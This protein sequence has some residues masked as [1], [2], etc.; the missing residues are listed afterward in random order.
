MSSPCKQIFERGCI[1]DYA[2]FFKFSMQAPICKRGIC[3][4]SGFCVLPSSSTYL[5]E[6]YLWLFSNLCSSSS[7]HLIWQFYDKVSLFKAKGVHDV[8]SHFNIVIILLLK[9]LQREQER[10]MSLEQLK[11]VIKENLK[12][13][14]KVKI[15]FLSKFI[16]ILSLIYFKI[17]VAVSYIMLECIF[18]LEL[19][20]HLH[21][22]E[23]IFFLKELLFF[24]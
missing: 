21:H 11:Q 14:S 17:L 15:S 18:H 19:M 10:Q 16:R 3:V 23:N 4:C 7:K 12:N 6:R 9:L 1:S 22:G 20:K 24:I 2:H 8:W 5:Q 13:K